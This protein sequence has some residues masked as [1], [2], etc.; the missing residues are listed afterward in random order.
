MQLSVIIPTLESI[1]NV[2]NDLVHHLAAHLNAYKDVLRTYFFQ[3]DADVVWNTHELVTVSKNNIIDYYLHDWGVNIYK[4]LRATMKS[5]MVFSTHVPPELWELILLPYLIQCGME[6]I[7][8]RCRRIGQMWKV[9]SMTT[10][11]SIW[12]EHR[13]GQNYIRYVGFTQI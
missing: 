2:Y 7:P 9:T 13:L 12:D 11:C 10:I 4:R 6:A 1:K 5:S 3:V 8:H